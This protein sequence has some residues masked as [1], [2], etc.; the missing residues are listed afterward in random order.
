MRTLAQIVS[1]LALGAIIVPPLLYLAGGL[2]LPV[3]KGWMLAATLVWFA[4]VPFWMGRE[5]RSAE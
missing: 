4:T 1:F 2:T 3:V 5:R